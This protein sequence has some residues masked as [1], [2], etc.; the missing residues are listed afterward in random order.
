MMNAFG[1]SKNTAGIASD[2]GKMRVV[3]PTHRAA[4]EKSK[5]E[6]AKL[7]AISEEIDR[8][9]RRKDFEQSLHQEDEYR[10]EMRERI[11]VFPSVTEE[12]YGWE[13]IGD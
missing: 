11:E 5:E 10:K 9:A 3:C 12:D 1:K 13:G 6:E 8:R 7:Q 4:E 2:P